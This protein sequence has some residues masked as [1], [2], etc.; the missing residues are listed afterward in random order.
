MF[1][2]AESSVKGSSSPDSPAFAGVSGKIRDSEKE[3]SA[4]FSEP[5][6]YVGVEARTVFAT[7]SSDVI[8]E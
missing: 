4:D 1:R 3:L 6:S 8:I 2:S 7:A 5:V